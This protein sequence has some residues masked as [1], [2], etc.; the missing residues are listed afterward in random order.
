M[1]TITDAEKNH[2]KTFEE[3]A[4]FSDKMELIEEYKNMQEELLRNMSIPKDYL[5]AWTF[6]GLK[7]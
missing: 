4:K 7:E 6:L 3:I 2:F 5:D 1:A